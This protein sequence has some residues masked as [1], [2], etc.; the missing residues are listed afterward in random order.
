MKRALSLLLL[1]I[2]LVA[3]P[4]TP[5]T[6][7][8]PKSD[9]KPA[10]EAPKGDAP[11]AEAPAA[12]SKPAEPKPEAKPDVT[13]ATTGDFGILGGTKPT[14]KEVDAE[15]PELRDVAVKD[16]GGNVKALYDFVQAV[17]DAAGKNRAGIN[18]MWILLTGFLVMFM[19][20]GFAMV[21]GG[22]TRA[23]NVSHTMAMNLM[24]YPIGMLGFW[25]CG[26]AIMFGGFGAF[27][28]LQGGD[29]LNK[30]FTYKLFDKDFGL[31][32]YEGFFLTGK[33]MDVG[34]LALFLFQMVF[35]DTT[36]TI[37]TG[38]MAER[39]KFFPFILYG[40]FISM[41]V[42]PVYGNWVWGGGWLAKL[43]TNFGLGHGHVD[44]AGCS[45]VHMVGGVSA[46]AG[47]LILGPRIGKYNKD[48]TVNVL[49]AHS[50][51][52]YVV[53][54]F[55][56]CFGWFGFNPG[57][58]LSGTDLNAAR[59]A[60][61]TMLA[62]ASGALIATIYMWAVY[63]KPDP[64]F[65]CNGMLAGLVAITAPC[66]F[67]TPVVAVL[68]GAIAGVLV[69]W[70]CL[71]WERIVKVDD[72]VGAISVHGVCGAWG[73]VSL[74]LFADGSYGQGWNG[75]FWYKLPDGTIK[76]A[77]EKVAELPKGWEEMG[78]TG[79]LYGSS[80]QLYAELIGI[81]ANIV[82]V[83]PVMFIFFWIVEKTIGNRVSAEVEVQGLDIP[84]M[85]VLG[86]INEDPKA[87]EGH[88]IHPSAEPRSAS[89]PP[90]G[91]RRYTLVVDG[92]DPGSLVST[93]SDLCQPNGEK[94]TPEFLGLYP[95][96][97]TMKGNR[98]RFRG[99]DPADSA[100]ALEKL[101]RN[102]IVG[103]AIKVRVE[104]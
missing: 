49:P 3:F 61:N 11:K 92:V 43:G 80:T 27:A 22:L 45:V 37:P 85:G 68:I 103:S 8:E 87:P 56:L 38:S 4:A 23:K 101:L 78:V 17:G 88:V 95:Y 55:I 76:W 69:I 72:P 57:S 96:M 1:G 41:L 33:A 50:V 64:S 24:I 32:G 70:S 54:T 46:L 34:L 20:A 14:L 53:G 47:A 73:I 97:T 74:G 18:M 59:I 99:G 67:V 77:A 89:Y 12:E 5:L 28:N 6:A 63:G 102:E 2:A 52:M 58:T 93:W 31:F 39:W 86:Y 65:M 10:A 36:C 81:A 15:K 84:E 100:L 16:I 62:S 44:F 25:I 35:M 19:Q 60:V 94:P 48:G 91:A 104:A 40:F 79:L 90:D 30:E 98:L 83:F 29:L 42:Y 26:Y 51:P 71:F 7:Q 9:P 13:G 75:S 66:A 82:W 21:E